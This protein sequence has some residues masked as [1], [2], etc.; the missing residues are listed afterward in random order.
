MKP[1]PSIAPLRP[2]PP[3]GTRSGRVVVKTALG[4]VA[5]AGLVLAVALVLA[6]TP[7]RASADGGV[8]APGATPPAVAAPR[9]DAGILDLAATVPIQDGGRVKPLQTYAGYTLLRINH[10]R[11][12]KTPQDESI[13][14]LEWL[15]DV[16]FRPDVASRYE[17]F[18]VETYEV[19]DAL[20]L[21][22]LDK[23]K[24]DRYAFVDLAPA[25]A[26]LEELTAK[27]GALD[28]KQ[29]SPVETGIVELGHS[30]AM[31]DALAHALDFAR[32]EVPVGGSEAVK[33]LFGGRDRVPLLD[34]LDKAPELLPLLGAQDPHGDDAAPDPAGLTADQ[35]AARAVRRRV[36]GLAE[37]GAFLDL[38]PPV[39]SRK[40]EPAWI[41]PGHVVYSAMQ[42]MEVSADQLSMMTRLVAMQAAQADPRVFRDNLSAYHDTAERLAG[43]RGEF[44]KIGLEV[45]L[46]GLDPFYRS[47]YLYVFAFLLMAVTWLRSNRWIRYGAWAFLLAGLGLHVT[48]IVLRCI[49]R[50]RPPISTLYETAIFISALATLLCVVAESI[51][52][53]HIALAVAP[54]VGAL[55]LFIAN[56]FEAL[57]GEDTMPQLEAVLDTNF[58][59]SVHVTCITIGYCGGL[60][61]AVLAHVL[62]LGRA[63]GL[64]RGNADFY[65]TIHRMNYGVLCFALLFSVV[66]TILGGIWANESWGRFWGWDPKENGAL[67][68]CLSQL[69]ILHARMGG[70]LKHFGFAMAS[71][72]SGCVIA[73]SW[74][75]VNLLGIGLH[76]YGFTGGIFTGLLTFYLVEV[77]VLL[78]GAVTWF[79]GRAY[80]GPDP[81]RLGA[82]TAA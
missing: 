40:Q 12:V 10:A 76:S 66:G 73:F 37:A 15:L 35:K 22:H 57:K 44:G 25:R 11:K 53:R 5:L 71:I 59:L 58:W 38:I 46:Y 34:V 45:T 49:L 32:A 70:Y 55:G 39:G 75:G 62:V 16:L 4:A 2:A 24:R 6:G 82:P 80:G 42:G 51:N 21:E 67:M 41:S 69:A 20:R 48:G 54:F 56:R 30:M 74:W 68:I 28:E 79:L 61:A 81:A 63:A 31:F 65:R 3:P 64:Q 7:S 47:V 18:L 52:R 1:S 29:R 60:L 72:G 26:K 77:G 23:K 27:Y 50:D 36:I 9:W 13:T 33:A 78:A 19:I 17:C 43:S 8:G 14:A